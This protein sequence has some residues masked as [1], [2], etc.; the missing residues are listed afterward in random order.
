MFCSAS[1]RTHSVLYNI[2]RSKSTERTRYLII[3]WL[4]TLQCIASVLKISIMILLLT[5]VQLKVRR[6]PLG[7]MNTKRSFRRSKKNMIKKRQH[8]RSVLWPLRIS[9]RQYVHWSCEGIR[10]Y[11]PNFNSICNLFEH[12]ATAVPSVCLLIAR[13]IGSMPLLHICK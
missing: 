6:K 4:I 10:D 5:S 1:K 2:S 11:A 8:L 3:L 12:V 7:G 9:L 13:Y